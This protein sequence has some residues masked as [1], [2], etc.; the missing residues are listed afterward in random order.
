MH[1]VSVDSS[2][3]REAQRSFCDIK[4][5]DLQKAVLGLLGD[6]D[7]S[8]RSFFELARTSSD[9]LKEELRQLR[10][11]QHRARDNNVFAEVDGATAAQE[12]GCPDTT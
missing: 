8:D 4:D 5:I 3:L 9:L 10:V 12:E 11:T 6:T 2:V 7:L 1:H